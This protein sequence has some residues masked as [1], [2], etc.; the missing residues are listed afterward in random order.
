MCTDFCIPQILSSAED[1]ETILLVKQAED[2]TSMES[3][4]SDDHYSAPLNTKNIIGLLKTN[5]KS[6]LLKKAYQNPP[7]TITLRFL[8]LYGDV[9][10]WIKFENPTMLPGFRFRSNNFTSSHK[11]LHLSYKM[12]HSS[13]Y[14]QQVEDRRGTW[15][16]IFEGYDFQKRTFPKFLFSQ[17]RTTP[18]KLVTDPFVYSECYNITK[19]LP[20]HENVSLRNCH[21]KCKTKNDIHMAIGVPSLNDQIN[22]MCHCGQFHRYRLVPRDLCPLC[23]DFPDLRCPTKQH[24][25]AGYLLQETDIAASIAHNYTYHH[26]MITINQTTTFLT[27]ADLK[28][29]L[30]IPIQPIYIIP[31]II[32]MTR[33][34]SIAKLKLDYSPY[35]NCADFKEIMEFS[36]NAI[37]IY[38]LRLSNTC[39]RPFTVNISIPF[40]TGKY[41]SAQRMV[42]TGRWNTASTTEG[43]TSSDIS[44][45]LTTKDTT[46]IKYSMKKLFTTS[47]TKVVNRPTT[48]TLLLSTVDHLLTKIATRS[49]TIKDFTLKNSSLVLNIKTSSKTV[50]HNAP[51]PAK[52]VSHDASEAGART[53]TTSNTFQSISGK[54]SR[55]TRSFPMK[56]FSLTNTTS[57]T[58][59]I[60][61]NSKE[62]KTGIKN[63]STHGKQN[64]S[65]QAENM[66]IETV[67]AERMKHMPFNCKQCIPYVNKSTHVTEN[68]NNLLQKIKK[69]LLLPKKNLTSYRR[70]LGS[71]EDNRQSAVNMGCVG[72]AVIVSCVVWIISTDVVNIVTFI[73]WMIKRLCATDAVL[74][75][76]E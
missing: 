36:S 53:L 54:N 31:K 39:V 30:K 44:S 26:H 8:N 47:A 55:F 5:Y 66:K 24:I 12:L 71:A 16:T 70:R 7:D 51:L 18:Y 64:R 21:L 33:R 75:R 68:I 34:C 3:F 27:G 6:M 49:S 69:K 20:S 23:P 63:L 62:L 32:M 56:A 73:V 17:S 15:F 11:I 14:W 41:I 19:S 29:E 35:S 2:G 52:T 13:F 48:N 28:P 59:M 38:C 58:A 50:T 76:L 43:V 65:N 72:M 60:Q 1:D 9:L 42:I 37:P 74:V 10:F 25:F 67:C 22:T 40:V 61:N 57:S 46:Q 45:G 4:L